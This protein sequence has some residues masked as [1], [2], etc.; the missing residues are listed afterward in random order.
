[1]KAIIIIT[2]SEF[3]QGRKQDKNGLFIAKNLFE[4]GVD[5]QG[6]IISPDSHYELVNYIKFA[7]DRADLV[8]ISGGLGPTTDDNTRIAVSE[9]IGVPLIYSEEWLNKLKAYYKSNNVEIT[10]ERKSMA[11]IPYGSA[12]IENP[13]GRAVGFIKVLDDVKK[14][15]VALPGVPS[16]MEPMFYKALEM[17]NIKEKKRYT[18]L[19]RV[20]GIKELDLNYILNDMKDLSYNF[21]PKG[22]D[23]FLYDTNFE[24]FKEKEKK[25]KDRLGTFIYAE[26]YLEM[27]EV[28]GKLLRENKKTVATAESSTGGLIVSRLV[29]VPGSSEYV[30]GGIVSYA[31]EVKIN[32]LKVNEEDIK[33]FGAVSEPVAKQMVEGVRN[34]I[35]SDLA[36]SDTGIAGPSGESPGKPLGLHYIGFTDGKE[37]KVYK[38]IYQGSRYDVRLYISQ[39][40][41]NLIRLYLINKS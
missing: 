6:I 31:N 2:G 37:T 34:L 21:S 8:F 29:N 30:L 27:E 35:N 33:N 25:I 22:I 40:A 11:K 24:S 20:F 32:L 23:V 9:A 12:I 10:E 13:V 16:E 14:A 38:E 15:V 39:F 28:V 3:V 17:L 26:D 19:F 5:I 4:R 36:V 41:L 1:M 7:L 18:K